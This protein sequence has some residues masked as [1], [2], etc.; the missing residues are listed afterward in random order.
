M[1]ES[2]S[3]SEACYSSLCGSH[4][5]VAR[6]RSILEL[7]RWV[8]LLAIL[9]YVLL[10]RRRRRRRSSDGSDERQH[11]YAMFLLKSVVLLVNY[12]YSRSKTGWRSLY[13]NTYA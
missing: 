11:P 10:R 4:L 6:R 8:V 1:E 3:F 13:L 2:G 12:I 7:L 9:G 5:G